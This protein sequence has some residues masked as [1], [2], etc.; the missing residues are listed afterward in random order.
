MQEFSTHLLQLPETL[1][2][3]ICKFDGYLRVF[4]SLEVLKVS[5]CTVLEC[6][7]E[8]IPIPKLLLDCIHWIECIISMLKLTEHWHLCAVPNDPRRVIVTK[9]TLVVEGRP[10]VDINL[11][12]EHWAEVDWECIRISI[13]IIRLLSFWC[14][15]CQNWLLCSDWSL[16]AAY[17]HSVFDWGNI[18]K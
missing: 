9:L 4:Q 7:L 14:S 3:L 11:T 6:F 5:V 8:Y 16:Q 17:K 13:V 18:G 12:G 10:D 2:K 1:S 15:F